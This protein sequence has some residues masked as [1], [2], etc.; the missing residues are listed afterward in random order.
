MTQVSISLK[1]NSEKEQIAK[2]L[3]EK[4]L[5]KWLIKKIKNSKKLGYKPRV[6]WSDE[7]LELYR[8][9]RRIEEMIKKGKI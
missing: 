7:K 5:K 9:T 8:D 2:N 3:L 1:N 4:I 6:V